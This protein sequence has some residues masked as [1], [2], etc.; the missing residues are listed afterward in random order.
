MPCLAFC[1]GTRQLAK[2][3]S[4]AMPLPDDMRRDKELA[5]QHLREGTRAPWR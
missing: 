3:T 2:N 4:K 5:G 1:Y